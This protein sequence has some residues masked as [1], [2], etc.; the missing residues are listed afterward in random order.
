MS[1]P[2]IEITVR[3][4]DF[5]SATKTK[6]PPN[7][8]ILQQHRFCTHFYSVAHLFPPLTRRLLGVPKAPRRYW[9]SGT[10]TQLQ[11]PLISQVEPDRKTRTDRAVE[12]YARSSAGVY[13]CAF[14]VCVRC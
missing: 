14:L 5:T 10:W 3:F 4:R 1:G 2:L 12:G 7:E 8:D 11:V 9:T 13:R 6:A